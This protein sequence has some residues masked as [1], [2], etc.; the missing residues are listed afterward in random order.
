MNPNYT[1]SIDTIIVLHKS[2]RNIRMRRRQ[3]IT[4]PPFEGLKIRFDSEAGDTQDVE[5]INLVYKMN[6]SEFY[7]EQE[8]ST[9]AD[10]VRDSEG[11][12]CTV[13]PAR[14]EEYINYYKSFGWEK[15]NGS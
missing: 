13:T 6:D 4:F 12:E 15:V 8:D 10:E 5:L 1:L 3:V 9:L 2:K 14:L 7:E 11:P